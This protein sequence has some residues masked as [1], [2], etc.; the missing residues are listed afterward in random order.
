MSTRF[1]EGLL[2][3]EGPSE[4]DRLLNAPDDRLL[5]KRRELWQRLHMVQLDFVQQL[6]QE[7]P[8]RPLSELVRSYTTLYQELGANSAAPAEVLEQTKEDYVVELDQ[9]DPH[10]PDLAA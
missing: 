7:Q 4:M 10:S 9:L 5:E 2:H 1:I 8:G 3:P 6:Q